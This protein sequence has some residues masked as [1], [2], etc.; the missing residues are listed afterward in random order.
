[1]VLLLA[2]GRAGARTER[3]VLHSGELSRIGFWEIRHDDEPASVEDRLPRDA[4]VLGYRRRLDGDL[5]GSRPMPVGTVLLHTGH[6]VCLGCC[7]VV[8]I[9]A[10]KATAGSLESQP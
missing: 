10:W 2:L 9:P 3:R 5:A 1:M 8:V 7:Q 4:Q 6:P